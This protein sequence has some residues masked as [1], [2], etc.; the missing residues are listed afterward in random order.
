MRF[1]GREADDFIAVA[2]AAAVGVAVV[3]D[4]VDDDAAIGIGRNGCTERCM[5]HHAAALQEA[6]EAFDLVDR[7][8]VADADVDAAAFFERAAAVDADEFAVGV[9]HRAAGIAGINSGVG[10]QAIGVF[11]QRAGWI[12]VAMHAGEDAV[13]DRGFEILGEQKR[14]ADDVDPFADAA[15]IAVAKLG[16]GKVVFAEEF[17]ECDVAARDRGRPAPHRRIGR[18]RGRISLRPRWSRRRGS[19]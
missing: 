17:D 8:G 19:S 1:R 12:L 7:N 13:G 14:V 10:L 18:R 2:Q 6:D 3:E 9:E 16:G 5:V 11:E 15:G 4:V